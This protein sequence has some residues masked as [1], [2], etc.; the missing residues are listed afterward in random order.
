MRR[1]N[2]I[3]M[4]TTHTVI[5]TNLLLR[6]MLQWLREKGTVDKWGS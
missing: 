6:M 2:T 3:P 4:T 5:W 1:A